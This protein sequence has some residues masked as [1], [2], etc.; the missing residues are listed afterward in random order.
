MF[1][2]NLVNVVL[3]LSYIWKFL[4]NLGNEITRES[5]K[6]YSQPYA[7][8]TLFGVLTKPSTTLVI[9]LKSRGLN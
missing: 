3:D 6:F 2:K 7:C 8:V 9:P 4:Y 5:R 1:A